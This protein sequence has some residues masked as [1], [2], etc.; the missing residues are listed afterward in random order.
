MD[1]SAKADDA[2]KQA[3]DR[4]A[5]TTAE[6]GQPSTSGAA[7]P[8]NSAA[9]ASTGPAGAGAAGPD[10]K[11]TDASGTAAAAVDEAA[12]AAKRMRAE[13]RTEL[14][15]SAGVRVALNVVRHTV[16]EP[17]RGTMELAVPSENLSQVRLKRPVDGLV[18]AIARLSQSV[19]EIHFVLT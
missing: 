1:G 4:A 16:I 3:G 5:A 10:G 15:E 9:V 12:P 19:L 11:V 8:G 17:H 13:S 14:D 2:D 6:V 18:I 7:A